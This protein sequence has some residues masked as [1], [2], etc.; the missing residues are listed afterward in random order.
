VDPHHVWNPNRRSLADVHYKLGMIHQIRGRYPEAGDEYRT[1]LTFD[2]EQA[3][4]R[5]A[6]Q[7]VRGLHLASEKRYGE[8]IAAYRDA[9]AVD[10]ARSDAHYDLGLAY[11]KLEQPEK[12]VGPFQRA[13]SLDPRSVDAHINLGNAFAFLGR[14]R[15]AETAYEAALRLDP[16]S[17]I[18]KKNLETV[19][20]A[21]GHRQR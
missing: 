12:A 6:Y 9:I 5:Y 17:L 13:L 4:V 10:P 1:S 2:P 20:R 8:A 3:E 15:D 11:L 14:Y 19:Q 16:H 18:A 21:P 7:L